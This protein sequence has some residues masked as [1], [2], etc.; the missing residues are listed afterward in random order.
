LKNE[1]FTLF[2]DFSTL[3]LFCLAADY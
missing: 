2:E 1:V 3:N